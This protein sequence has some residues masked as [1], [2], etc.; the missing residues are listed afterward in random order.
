M[1]DSETHKMTE[2]GMNWTLTGEDKNKI[3][4]GSGQRSSQPGA[5][6]KKQGKKNLRSWNLYS[7]GRYT[8]LSQY[9]S[10]RHIP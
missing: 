9:T 4:R 1:E 3:M 10:A 6:Q 2:T 5:R 7:P 8:G